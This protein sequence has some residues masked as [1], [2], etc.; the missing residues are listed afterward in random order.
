MDIILPYLPLFLTLVT[1]TVNVILGFKG[2]N[3]L[4][5]IILNILLIMLSELIGA[6]TINFLG[7]VIAYLVSMI[8]DL[9][10]SLIDKIF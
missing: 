2:A 1:I 7:D 3:L 4:T 6:S 8:I 9:F 10:S 5:F